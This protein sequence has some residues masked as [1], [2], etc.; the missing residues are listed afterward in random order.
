MDEISVDI[1][2]VE[3]RTKSNVF[4]TQD[5]KDENFIKW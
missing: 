2:L 1:W 4:F 5:V 3:H